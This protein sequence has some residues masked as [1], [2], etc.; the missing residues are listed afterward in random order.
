MYNVFFKFGG[1]DYYIDK[2]YESPNGFE[3]DIWVNY[4]L[5]EINFRVSDLMLQ[6]NLTQYINRKKKIDKLLGNIK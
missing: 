2:R 1:K 6:D 3:Y 5:G 4:G